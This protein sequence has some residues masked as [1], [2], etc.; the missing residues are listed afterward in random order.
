MGSTLAYSQTLDKDVHV[1]CQRVNC[2]W[3]FYNVFFILGTFKITK[4]DTYKNFIKMHILVL[5]Q[6]LQ[7]VVLIAINAK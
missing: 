2:E 1:L 5:A 7:Q 3:F 4:M 6:K